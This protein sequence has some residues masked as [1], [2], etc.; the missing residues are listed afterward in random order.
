[1]KKAA[2]PAAA[3]LTDASEPAGDAA[4]SEPAEEAPVAPDAVAPSGAGSAAK[5]GFVEDSQDVCVE[6]EDDGM[7]ADD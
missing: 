6:D 7:E 1:M 4:A 2:A 3:S 5:K